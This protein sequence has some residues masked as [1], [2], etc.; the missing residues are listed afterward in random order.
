ML[1]ALARSSEI[2]LVND[3]SRDDSWAV[4]QERLATIRQRRGHRSDA[5]LR[6][7]QRAA[8]RAS[9]LERRRRFDDGR[10]P[11][12][13]AGAYS[14]SAGP[15][16][17]RLR[18]RLRHA[19]EQQHGFLR[20]LASRI[21]KRVLEG[22][23][24]AEVATRISAWRAIRRAAITAFGGYRDA[25]V[26]IDVLLTW[27]TSRFA[28]VAGRARA[29]DDRRVELYG[30]EAG[31]SRAEH[32]DRIQHGPSS[33][34]EF[35]RV[36]FHAVWDRRSGLCRWP[37]LH[38]RRQRPRFSVPRIRDRDFLRRAALRARNHRRISR[39]NAHAEHGS[40]GLCGSKPGWSSALSKS[41]SVTSAGPDGVVVDDPDFAILEWD[42]EKF[43]FRVARVRHALPPG[44][45]RRAVER[46]RV[47]GV[48]LAYYSV[49]EASRLA[50]RDAA[51]L[52]AT[53][54]DT[55]VTLVR[56]VVSA[57]R[58]IRGSTPAANGFRDRVVRAKR[59]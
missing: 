20:N 29:A 46:M 54:I 10:R 32:A 53:L 8:V 41:V 13:S 26:S 28:W 1:P 2:L 30:R 50:A 35:H 47:R 14:S 12:T 24:G 57:R 7:A 11:S 4:V 33:A 51:D 15:S 42:S 37:V 3:G 58:D 43:G 22:A 49:P 31:S 40:P 27:G 52:G 18:R 16:C 36:P 9:S 39:A 21:T 6:P 34:R 56:R 17:R 55:R 25:F 38:F 23:M 19:A 45:L 59:T 44:D 48:V 5:K